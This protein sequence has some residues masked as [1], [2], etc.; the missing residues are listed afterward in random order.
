MGGLYDQLTIFGGNSNPELTRAI[1]AYIDIPPGR[2][3]VF[4][5]SNEN[6]FVRI[7]E[8]VRENDVFVIQ[9]FSSPVNE[10]IM[11]LLIIIDAL[12]RASAGRIT[13]VIPYYAYGRT[14]KKD[15]PRVPITARLIADMI[16]VAGADRIL[17]VD[18]HAGQIQGFFN[19]PV[20]EMTALPILARYFQ[21]KRLENPVVVSPDL[22]ST[23]R[24]RNFAEELDAP[25]AIIEKRRLGND[26]RTEVLNL[27]GSV[28]DA[29]VILIDDEI[30]TAGSITQ[31]AELCIARGAREVYAACT[32]AVLSG[33]AVERLALSPIK[34][35]VVTDT[36][37]LPPHKR[38]DKITVLSV[39]P[40]L[41][42]SIQRIHT[43]AS[44]SLAYRSA[45]RLPLR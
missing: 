35:I 9:S 31:A 26:D 7:G 25:L 21:E 24:A 11:E 6:I 39:A 12:K 36:I 37:P 27:I 19:I 33:P 30:D 18:L 32:H 29:Q 20:D 44:V 14:D 34:E 15:Q 41:G 2:I 5:F 10:S 1:C 28:D 40:L 8:S 22:G 16:T 3:E 23:K 13:A 17:T 45:G 43:G 42:E 38:L 4:K